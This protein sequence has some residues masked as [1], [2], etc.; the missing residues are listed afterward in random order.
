MV[1][2][3]KLRNVVGLHRDDAT[4][5]NKS[6]VALPR[7]ALH[8]RHAFVELLERRIHVLKELSAIL[9][10]LDVAALLLKERHT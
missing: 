9:G 7:I 6:T 4:K 2:I 3:Q 8:D 10:K 1:L 5:I